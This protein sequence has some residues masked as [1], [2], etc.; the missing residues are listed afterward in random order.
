MSLKFDPLVITLILLVI[1][2][3]FLTDWRRPDSK[4][5]RE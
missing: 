1:C 3:L 5:E 4:A 2:K